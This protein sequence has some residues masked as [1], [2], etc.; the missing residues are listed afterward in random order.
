MMLDTMYPGYHHKAG[1]TTCMRLNKQG[2]KDKL[3][4]SG[5]FYGRGKRGRKMI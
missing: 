3:L 5:N 4:M 1:V 2:V